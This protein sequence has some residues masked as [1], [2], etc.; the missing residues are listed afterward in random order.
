[1]EKIVGSLVGVSHHTFDTVYD[2]IFTTERV[3]AFIIQQPGDN[4]YRSTSMLK[5]VFLG[6]MLTKRMEQ[7]ERAKITQVRRRRLQEIPIDELVAQHSLNFEIHYT[8]VTS[9]EITRG[10]FQSQLR[11]DA[12]N[13]PSTRQ[14]IRFTISKEQISDAQRLLELALAS[15]I[16][17]K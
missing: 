10:L 13:L 17:G 7:S 5:D 2:L 15:K 1:M 3:I 12:S 16:K 6:S 4:P 14:T 9:C 8:D 11:F